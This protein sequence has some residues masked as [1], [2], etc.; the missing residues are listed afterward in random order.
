MALGDGVDT[1]NA[2]ARSGHAACLKPPSYLSLELTFNS[3]I[4]VHLLLKLLK[5]TN[6][7]ELQKC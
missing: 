4:F 7:F 6:V 5:K 2:I 3:G 1:M